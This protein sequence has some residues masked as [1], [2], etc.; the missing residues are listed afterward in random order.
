MYV[1]L[2]IL[3]FL[4]ALALV[5]VI[6]IQTGK[7]ADIGAAFGGGS[8]QTVFGGRGPT[9]F[10]HRLTSAIA[11]LFMATSIVLTMHAARQGPASVIPD[12]PAKPAPASPASP[13]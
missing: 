10:L 7:G 3:H 5:G 9:T 1:V 11:A 12:E 6:L 13:Q 2:I 8:S 4:L